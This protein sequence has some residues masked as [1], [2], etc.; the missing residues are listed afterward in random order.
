MM[1]SDVLNVE[2]VVSPLSATD[3]AGAIAELVGRLGDLGHIGDVEGAL[4]AV[5][6][7]E[8]TRSTG[9]GHGLAVPHGKM[10]GC[11]KLT[12]AV[13]V[14]E[15]GIEFDSIDGRPVCIV[16][17]LLSS[18][19]QT[20][21]HIQLLARISRLMSKAELREAVIGAGD[22]AGVFRCLVEAEGEVVAG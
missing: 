18:P 2:C 6:A 11:E 17:L 10:A 12:A 13:G 9:I 7:R 5:M 16:F 19:Q 15:G 21:E 4:E 14:S 3:K 22:G 1:L 20:G 8:K